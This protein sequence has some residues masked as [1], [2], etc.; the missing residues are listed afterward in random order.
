MTG[1]INFINSNVKL[2]NIFVEKSYSEDAIN[3]VNSNFIISDLDIQNSKSDG[4]DVDFSEG[5][6]SRSKFNDI[7]GDAIDLSGSKISIDNVN[8]KNIGDK[9]ISVGENTQL[10]VIN[11]NISYSRIGIAS[12]DASNVMGSNINI[13]NCGLF[14]FAVYQKKKYFSGAILKIE[15]NSSCNKSLVQLG[16]ELVINNVKI[17]EKNFNVKKLYD[18]TLQ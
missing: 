13:S 6:I 5:K 16:N 18:G 11:A 3:L 17:T 15:T 1:G 14:D 9:A 2:T 8:I 4:I 7:L 10:E 12:K